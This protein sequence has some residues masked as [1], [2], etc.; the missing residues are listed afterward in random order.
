M[1]KWLKRSMWALLT[2]LVIGSSIGY[3]Y[4]NVATSRDAA[5]FHPQGRMIDI[6]AGGR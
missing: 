4:Q 3:V 1:L 2:L 6:G 5:R